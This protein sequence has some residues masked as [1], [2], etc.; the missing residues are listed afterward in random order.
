MTLRVDQLPLS[1]WHEPVAV[2]LA[3]HVGPAGSRRTRASAAALWFVLRRFL[4][5]LDGLPRP[6]LTP[7]T[8]TV[9]HLEAF[10]RHRAGTRRDQHAVSELREVGRMLRTEPL[11]AQLAGEIGDYLS[12]RRSSVSAPL[13]G[14]SDAELHRLVSAARSDV[15]AIRRRVATGWALVERY[16]RGVD[17]LPHRDRDH[18]RDLAEIAGTGVVPSPSTVPAGHRSALSARRA[19]A[20]Q[21][22]LTPRDVLPLL[23]LLAAVTGRNGESLKELPAQH[24]LLEDKA[25]EVRLTKR[26]G[27]P[28]DWGETVTWEI[29]RPDRQLHT[30]GGLYLLLL[31]WTAASRRLSGTS[32]AW[33]IWSNGY[34]RG[35]HGTGEH[36]DPFAT[37]LAHGFYADRW[38]AGHGLLTDDGLPLPVSFN[39]IRTSI[40]VRRTKQMGGHLPSAARAHTVPVLFANYLRNDPTTIGCSPRRPR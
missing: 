26:R 40:E 13:P 34:S 37:T 12:R 11:A 18:A 4:L 20:E 39:R 5:F 24:R 31:E 3:R 28:G 30:P 9:E 15:V 22:Y 23:V 10:L 25:V 33:S 6:P 38:A 2:M 16:G 29:G 35:T 14:Y 19:Q 17:T 7:E 36:Y 32:S 27:G 8:L 1:G 21:L